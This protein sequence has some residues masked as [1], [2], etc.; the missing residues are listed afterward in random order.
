ML[1]DDDQSAKQAA[2]K[3]HTEGKYIMVKKMYQ[4]IAK[5]AAARATVLYLTTTL[6]LSQENLEKRVA[7]GIWVQSPST[8]IRRDPTQGIDARGREEI[9]ANY[10]I[11]MTS[12]TVENGLR[13]VI[14]N[15][16]LYTAI[17]DILTPDQAKELAAK[18]Y[19]GNFKMNPDRE[20]WTTI[21]KEQGI[22]V[23]KAM[24][25]LGANGQGVPGKTLHPARKKTAEELTNG[26]IDDD[27]AQSFHIKMYEGK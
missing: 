2:M 11:G 25:H 16:V 9:S 8:M 15:S 5:Y 6:A 4:T 3:Q 20:Q 14:I 7:L 27:E 17:K 10:N 19:K 13:N 24:G 26:K 23:L 12:Y 22:A 21:T 1:L 18:A